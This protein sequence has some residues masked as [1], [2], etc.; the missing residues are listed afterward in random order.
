MAKDRSG[1]DLAPQ[2]LG[3]APRIIN[4]LLK[5]PT[6]TLTGLSKRMDT[7]V[8]VLKVSTSWMKK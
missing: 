1:A 4:S 3:D 2:R 7:D 8:L 6:T 5:S